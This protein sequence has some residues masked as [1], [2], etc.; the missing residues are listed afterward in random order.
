MRTAIIGY[1]RMGR[2]IETILKQR[3]HSVDLIIDRDNAAD[4]N[5]ESL[6]AID[7][8]IEFT[9][10]EMAYNNIRTCI[11]TTT[12]VVSGTT[13]WTERL[14]ELKGLCIEKGSAM[15]YASNYS[16]GVNLMFKLN[17]ELAKMMNKVEGYKVSIDEVHHI[18]K[19]DSPSG[20][21]I[22]IAD[23]IIAELDGNDSWVNDVP[24]MDNQIEIHSFREGGV[25]GI[26]TVV[27]DAVDDALEIKH[28]IKNR[29]TLALGAV[30]AAEFVCG[31]KGV[32]SM[33]DLLK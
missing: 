27:Y 26:H 25:A 33:N 20:T 23:Q 12:P 29:R 11:E 13:G 16:L 32:F 17:S 8:A 2:E 9:I 14:E 15:F 22:S 21:A 7:V 24:A 10:P 31:E 18:H 30:L 1:G 4:L 19:L 3:G 5:A 6:A 28:T